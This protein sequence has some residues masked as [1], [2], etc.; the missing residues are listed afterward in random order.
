MQTISAIIRV[1][2]GTEAIMRGAL[3]AVAAHVR[4]SEPE[5]IGFHISQGDED[6]CVFTTYERFAD[7]ASMDRHNNS[8]TVAKFFATVQPILDGPVILVTAMEASSKPP[9]AA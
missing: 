1:R 6:P 2:P 9:P 4:D 3:L 7:R 8:E 5:T